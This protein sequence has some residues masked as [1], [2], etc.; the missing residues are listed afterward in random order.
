MPIPCDCSSPPR[1]P[2]SATAS[3]FLAADVG[4]TESGLL[5]PPDAVEAG[6]PSNKDQSLPAGMK[7]L[8]P[9]RHEPASTDLESERDP[10]DHRSDGSNSTPP[11]VG[12]AAEPT[13]VAA[14]IETEGSRRE[15]EP[16]S[17]E[18]SP[19]QPGRKGEGKG[20]PTDSKP[21]S[22]AEGALK[23]RKN[24]GDSNDDDDDDHSKLRKHDKLP[25]AQG[26]H[27]TTA[28]IV[29]DDTK[30]DEGEK[31]EK[32]K[33]EGA[34]SVGSTAALVVREGSKT[35]GALTTVIHA[36]GG[37]V[38]GVRHSDSSHHHGRPH[39]KVKHSRVH[40]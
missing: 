11:L 9:Y 28:Q 24:D 22:E 33:H 5:Q 29:V 1:L 17:A 38:E 3:S 6:P 34:P 25:L 32:D 39:S 26:K 20:D 16:F 13:T 7:E 8:F 30:R 21:P 15:A 18:T 36:G 14:A 40:Y 10:G 19:S 35:E 27:D 12:H 23:L 31:P 2:L 4:Q 37:V